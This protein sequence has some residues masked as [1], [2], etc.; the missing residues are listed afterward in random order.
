MD[1]PRRAGSVTGL[2]GILVET[3]VGNVSNAE[4]EI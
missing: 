2:V 4:P 3:G 1:E